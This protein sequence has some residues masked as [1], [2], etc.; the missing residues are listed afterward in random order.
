[1]THSHHPCN[2]YPRSRS[3]LVVDDLSAQLAPLEMY[4]LAKLTS[5]VIDGLVV[6]AA[7]SRKGLHERALDQFDLSGLNK[8]DALSAGVARSGLGRTDCAR[9]RGF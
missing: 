3:R 1:M 8:A 6:L 9:S 4:G 2:D 7:A 5:A